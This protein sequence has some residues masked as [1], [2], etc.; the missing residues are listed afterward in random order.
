MHVCSHVVNKTS[1]N[2]Q[3]TNFTPLMLSTHPKRLLS[4]EKIR[5]KM[6]NCWNISLRTTH[7]TST[8][9]RLNNPMTTRRQLRN[10]TPNRR[11]IQCRRED[12]WKCDADAKRTK[13]SNA[14][15]KA[16]AR[17]LNNPTPTR[18]LLHRYA[19]GTKTC[20]RLCLGSAVGA[21]NVWRL[22]E[23]GNFLWWKL[24]KRPFRQVRIKPQYKFFLVF[25]WE[26]I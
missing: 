11:K 19:Q 10:P 25:F 1:M 12:N 23:T 8:R 2:V 13:Q 6:L 15:S 4:I 26:R 9:R 22:N 3:R 5:T 24:S 7:P 18:R 20:I 21:E 17:Q 16:P 14:N